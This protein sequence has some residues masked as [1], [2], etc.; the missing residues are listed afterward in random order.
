MKRNKL[1]KV[2]N[3]LNNFFSIEKEAIKQQLPS[4]SIWMQNNELFQT[5]SNTHVQWF[6]HV[7]IT[8][9]INIVFHF[10]EWC[11]GIKS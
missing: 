8:V 6:I 1:I 5:V 2:S 10:R 3:K 9:I 4:L 11:D 7:I